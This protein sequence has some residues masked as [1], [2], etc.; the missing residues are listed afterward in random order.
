MAVTT[1]PAIAPFG[2]PG[3]PGTCP[4]T[5]ARESARE[6]REP[7]LAGQG[8]S[9]L[10]I[11]MGSVQRGPSVLD[12]M[13]VPVAGGPKGVTH[14]LSA[15]NLPNWELVQV[16]VPDFWELWLPKVRDAQDAS[17]LLDMVHNGVSI[18]RPPASKIVCSPNWPSAHEF[19][20]KVDEVIRADLVAG[21][22]L[23]PFVTP[24]FPA[25]I[26]SPLGAFLKRDN[27]KI[28]LIHDLSFPVGES[29]NHMIDPEDFSLQYESVDS[30]VRACR[31]YDSPVLAKIDLQD[32]YKAVGIRKEDW[33]LMGLK[34]SLPGYEGEFYFSK[35]L[36]FGLRSAPAL[37]DAFA[38]VIEDVMAQSGV[39]SRV[40]RYVDDF[41]LVAPNHEV[42]ASHLAIM[43]EVATS[44]GFSIQPSKVVHPTRV[45]EFL[46]IVVDLERGVLRISDERMEEVR[47]I[48]GKWATARVISKRN[49]L[50]LVGKLAFAARVV[51]TG[52]AFLGRLIGLAK[53]ARALHHRVR[54]SASARQDLSWWLECISSHNGTAI[55]DVDWSVGDIIHVFSD[56]SDFGS[57]AVCQGEWWSIV[58]TS[59][60]AF[61]REMSIN[62]R[63]LHA[64]VKA[65]ATWAPH[66]PGA[67]VIF[68]V[69]NSTA[70][71]ILNKLYTPVNELMELVRHWCLVVEKYKLST[72]VVYISTHDNGMA[73]AISRG[74]LDRFRDL[75]GGEPVRIWPTPIPYFDRLV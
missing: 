25:Y 1:P 71:H 2:P 57:G 12:A 67:R 8:R 73:D 70:C 33:H 60:S 21:K 14:A 47:G 68:H 72:A 38:Q 6:I 59:E 69:D 65:V 58:Y 54:L 66:N 34:W 75:H 9:V 24:P 46:G 22:L 37:F 39:D 52:R 35:V 51:R 41:L 62:W 36:S 45:T 5:D 61:C 15:T 53:T 40:I 20:A 43:I 10:S 13:H 23:G 30:A 32:A 63:E 3:R 56:A 28:R 64:V 7:N 18:G 17:R 31:S 26:V 44:A 55:V 48:L 16:L 29:V 11:T 74:E 4:G 50:K 42:A 27:T 19:A 49:L